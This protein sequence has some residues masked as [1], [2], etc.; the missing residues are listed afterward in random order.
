MAEIN[1]TFSHTN[2]DKATLSLGTQV[3]DLTNSSYYLWNTTTVS[4]GKYLLTLTVSDK[5]GN[6]QT[7]EI[8][9]TVDNTLPIDEIRSPLNSTCVKGTVDVTFYG[10]DANLANMRLHINGGSALQTWNTSGTHDHSWDT[11]TATDGLHTITLIICDKAGD[12]LTTSIKVNV[13]NTPPTV[14][15]VSP[16]NG[17]T[18]SRVVT[19][20][21]TANDANNFSLVLFIDNAQIIVYPY[22]TFQWNT[23]KLVDGNHTIRIVATDFAGNT[24]EQNIIVKTANAAP[25][26]MTYIG[27]VS[28]VILGLVLGALV[29]SVWL[30]RKPSSPTTSAT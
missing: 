25:A 24:K 15:I 28:A 20:N 5:A 30:K 1:V 19:I 18:V 22:Q 8:T 12:Q 4:D 10:Y 27:Y 2:L 6:T 11:T 21:Y 3:I 13:D 7:D 17:T 26:Y 14:S 29:V 9:V 23:T 16:Q